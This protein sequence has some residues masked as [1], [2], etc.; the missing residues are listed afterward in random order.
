MN[1]LHLEEIEKKTISEAIKKYEGNLSKAA[2]ELG[3]GRSTLYRKM[4]KY[5]LS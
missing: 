3:L 2:V 4:E 5:G 1:T